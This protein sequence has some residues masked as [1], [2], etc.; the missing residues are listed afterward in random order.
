MNPPRR[1]RNEKHHFLTVPRGKDLRSPAFILENKPLHPGP[2]NALLSSKGFSHFVILGRSFFRFSS[3][4]QNSL[5]IYPY[6]ICL[7]KESRI[8]WSML[9]TIQ[10]SG[11][12]GRL[13]FMFGILPVLLF[14]WTA[15]LVAADFGDYVDPTFSCP[16]TTTCPTV[17]VASL[18]DCPTTCGGNRTQLCPNGECRSLSETCPSSAQNPCPKCL[19]VACA[20]IIS[21]FETCE[22]DYEP[23]YQAESEC[24]LQLEEQITHVFHERE[25]IVKAIFGT[26]VALVTL[27]TMAWT[28][29]NQRTTT[30]YLE[31]NSTQTGYRKTFM[32][33]CLYYAVGVTLVGFQ[34]VL[35]ILAVASYNQERQKEALAHFEIVWCI[36]F[37]WTLVYKWPQHSI[38]SVF[39]KACDLNSATHICVFTNY[40]N[41]EFR[42]GNDEIRSLAAAAL[43]KT[44]TP[45][46]MFAVNPPTIKEPAYITNLRACLG[47]LFRLGN[48]ALQCFFRMPSTLQGRVQYVPIQ[49]QWR[50][51]RTH[52]DQQ[53]AL[54][55]RYIVHEF[56]RYNFSSEKGKFVP[57]DINVAETVASIASGRN[58]LTAQQ[59]VDRLSLCGP[60]LIEMPPP[61][62][63]TCIADEFSKTFY[64]Y[65]LYVQQLDAWNG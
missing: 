26:W 63:G 59:A 37:V 4:N 60:N 54:P 13:S 47:C 43:G 6:P 5:S 9:P 42:E 38:Q 52:P 10:S 15:E 53:T 46:S 49:E 33:Q 14:L 24:R 44:S 51:D 11:S 62:L 34:L 30:L 3:D 36:A 16:A 22:L 50:V 7:D 61:F 48:S 32:G 1:K 35:L 58:G 41:D 27:A 55:T 23:Y 21:S 25:D 45:T 17:C 8:L 28:W 12:M 29:S 39:Y 57:G 2:M 18:L 20:K 56:R 64:V 19:P 31:K 65:Q 40:N